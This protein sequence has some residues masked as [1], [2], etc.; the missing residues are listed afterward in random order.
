MKN[1]VLLSWFN[2]I[3]YIGMQ[4]NQSDNALIASSSQPITGTVSQLVQAYAGHLQVQAQ[5]E[6]TQYSIGL[7]GGG[8]ACHSKY[9]VSYPLNV[10]T[11]L[12]LSVRLCLMYSIAKIFTIPSHLR[13]RI[14]LLKKSRSA[15]GNNR[16]ACNMFIY[17]RLK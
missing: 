6:E 15:T 1:K 8:S 10:N 12:Q 16:Y 14:T 2:G 17:I 11:T 3:L 7:R 9:H 5:L 4:E 13:I